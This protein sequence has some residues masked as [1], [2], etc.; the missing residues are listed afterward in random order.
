MVRELR[1]VGRTIFEDDEI[2]LLSDRVDFL[3]PLEVEGRAG[4]VLATAT[5]VLGQCRDERDG[6]GLRDGVEDMGGPSLCP[7]VPCGKDSLEFLGNE[8]TII[9][10][11]G[12]PCD[13]LGGDGIGQGRESELVSKESVSAVAKEPEALCDPIT[14]AE[15]E[16]D[17]VIPRRM[18]DANQ[19]SQR[20]E[21]GRD[22]SPSPVGEGGAQRECLW[23]LPVRNRLGRARAVSP[24]ENGIGALDS[25][26]LKLD[27][28]DWV[29]ANVGIACERGSPS[30]NK[31]GGERC[32]SVPLARVITLPGPLA[33]AILQTFFIALGLRSRVS[34]QR[35]WERSGS[36]RTS[37][38]TAVI[39]LRPKSGKRT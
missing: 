24:F 23:A 1:K 31:H 7:G 19:P 27:L 9:D 25:R 39:R 2:I 11:D 26:N 22:P 18:E 12:G 30:Q 15:S 38:A 28:P 29:K 14:V 37:S 5:G 16:G 6:E 10:F 33:W 8:T 4:R 17:Q 21:R 34:W 32:G 13:A 20:L 3:P 36:L 35:W